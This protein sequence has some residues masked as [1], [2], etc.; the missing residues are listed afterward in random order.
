M[1]ASIDRVTDSQNWQPPTGD[2][3]NNDGTTG[4]VPTDGRRTDDRPADGRPA[5]GEYSQTGGFPP[6]GRPSTGYAPPRGAQPGWTPPPKPGLIPLRPLSFGALLGTPFLVLRRNP[7]ATFG[8]ALLIQAGITLFSLLVVGLVSYFAFTRVASAPQDEQAAVEAGATVTVILSALIPMALS[9]VASALLQGIIVLEVARGTLG[10]KLRMWALWRAAG[11]RLWPLVLWTILLFAAVVVSIAIVGGLT[12]LFAIL[13]GVWVALAFAVGIIGGLGLLVLWA[14]LYTKTSLVPSL[15][16]LERLDIRSSVGRSWHLTNG[17][18]WRTFGIQLLVA[19]MINIVAQ[20]VTTPL[21]LLFGVAVTLVDPNGAFDAYIP[22]IILYV[23]I[24][25]VA[26]V[27][28]AVTSVIQSATTALIYIDL[29]MRKEGL[30]LDLAR[31]VE[32]AQ[33]SGASLP[34]PY[35]APAMA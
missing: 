29:R 19:V 33:H 35:L 31:F 4:R 5:Y 7:K 2:G 24:L 25:F 17:Y 20:V 23:L 10:E 9:L 32:S 14:W 16:V 27:L 30:D 22:S 34:D 18:F 8:S 12:A 21:S 15:I 11:R 3:T 6:P 26:L 13:G 28:G 1:C